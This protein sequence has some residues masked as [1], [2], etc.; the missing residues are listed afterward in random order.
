MT[1]SL[2]PLSI[3]TK[4]V[5]CIAKVM[6]TNPNYEDRGYTTIQKGQL[7]DNVWLPWRRHVAEVLKI[8]VVCQKVGTF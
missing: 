4:A 8:R 7:S 5:E 2:I 6:M 1:G 3:E